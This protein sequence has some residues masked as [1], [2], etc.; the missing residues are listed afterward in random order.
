MYIRIYVCMYVLKVDIDY[1]LKEGLLKLCN[2]DFGRGLASFSPGTGD[3]AGSPPREVVV[4]AEAL[5]VHS[6]TSAYVEFVC[7]I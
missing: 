4:G 6:Q 5:G 3:F 1:G 7:L 2:L